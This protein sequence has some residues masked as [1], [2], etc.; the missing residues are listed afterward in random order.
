MIL[1]ALWA[2][3]LSL[4]PVVSIDA[5]KL[6]MALP[7]VWKDE[8]FL[9][10]RKFN[11]KIEL[12][13]MNIDYLYAL[14][15]KFFDWEPLPKII[16]AS[17]LVATGIL[18]Y[19][20]VSKRYGQIYGIL[21]YWMI[22]T[23]PINQRLASEVYVDLGLLFFSSMSVIYYL[24]A[25]EK[26]FNLK[27]FIIS[28]AACGLAAGSKFNGLVFA[29]IMVMIVLHETSK[30]FDV[31]KMLLLTLLFSTAI[32]V[33]ISPWLIRN[34]AG[35]GGN[36]FYPLFGSIFSSS[37]IQNPATYTSSQI[38]QGY[39]TWRYYNGESLLDVILIPLRF[40][41]TG[42]DYDHFQ[43]DGVLNPLMLLLLVL[44]F[45][46]SQYLTKR[47]KFQLFMI[48]VFMLVFASYYSS[49]AVRYALPF[50]LP[51][52][53]L[54]IEGL[55]NSFGL[56]KTGK[57]KCFVPCII[58]ASLIFFN[59]NY[60]YKFAKR[61]SV[62]QYLQG[63]ITK[64]EYLKKHVISYDIYEFI[65][66]ELPADA[67]IY[68]VLCGNKMYYVNR[69]YICSESSINWWFNGVVYRNEGINSFYELLGNLPNTDKLKAG[70]LLINPNE[71]YKSFLEIYF[72]QD[73]PESIKNKQ[74]LD[75]FINF[76]KKQ[77]PLFISGELILFKINYDFPKP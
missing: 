31:K 7:S 52:T 56:V 59:I 12:G 54:N 29:F 66:S 44:S 15:L 65:N 67:V 1:P 75:S 30:R 20:F 45:I 72:D 58:I 26:E 62:F 27:Y 10:F 2:L 49:A 9:F 8:G 57:F 18:T 50:T 33:L 53:I 63:N 38:S 39:M 77:S 37:A 55:K 60:S 34:Y 22:L 40:F 48:V 19:R 4:R 3:A 25:F 5:L 68:D 16:H 69:K 35:S 70:Y 71:F 43:F 36:P 23:L 46:K 61:T 28:A 51:L 42:K 13:M 6:H 14:L 73:D 17:F 24:R 32:L 41:L 76:L 21:S 11:A 47:Q 64:E 74:K